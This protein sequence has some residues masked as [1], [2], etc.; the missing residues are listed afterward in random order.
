MVLRIQYYLILVYI[1]PKFLSSTT[2]IAIC[3]RCAMKMSYND[4]KPDGN[5]PGLRVCDECWDSKDR[6]RLA[7]RT[8]ENVTLISARPDTKLDP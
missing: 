3:D 8:T 6:W 4:L 5:V 2:S 1:V 7:P